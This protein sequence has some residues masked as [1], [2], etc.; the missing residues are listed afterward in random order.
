MANPTYR[1]EALEEEFGKLERS[2]PLVELNVEADSIITTVGRKAAD[3]LDLQKTDTLLDIG[4][5]LGRWAFFYAPLC[6][7]VVGIDISE[8]LIRQAREAAHQAGVSN[9]RFYRGSFENLIESEEGADVRPNKVL[10]VYS[11]HHLTDPMK[12]AFLKRLAQRWPQPLTLVIADLMWFV[13]P[14]RLRESWDDVFYDEGD[15]DFPPNAFWLQ[16]TA[17]PYFD[18]TLL[19]AVHPLVGLLVAQKG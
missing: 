8:P 12:A 18:R 17:R 3:W 4:T 16:E 5:G 15:T 7:E 14:S 19:V 11:F 6:K 2:S 13:D 9:V 10:C 1:R